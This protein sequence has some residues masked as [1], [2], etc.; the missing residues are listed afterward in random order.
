MRRKLPPR[1][2]PAPVG[3]STLPMAFGTRLP[4]DELISRKVWVSRLLQRGAT[5]SALVELGATRTVLNEL[6]EQQ[7]AP[8]TPGQVQYAYGLVTSEWKA[9]ESQEA[10]HLRVIA[11]QRIQRDLLEMRSTKP[12]P[13]AA[14][15]RHEVLLA[16]LQGTK[17]PVR[18]QFQ[19]NLEVRAT[20]A[21]VVSTFTAEEFDALCDEQEQVE[22]DAAS[23]RLVKGEALSA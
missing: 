4:A 2:P 20:L 13:W 3:R 18:V 7:P 14:I 19:G 12:V 15:Q 11:V 23:L 8:L 9:V 16:D 5:L 21:A 22:R 17:M 6:G 1:L 10:G